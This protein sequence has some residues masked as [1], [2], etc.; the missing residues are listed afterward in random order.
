M[1]ATVRRRNTRHGHAG[2][3]S[4][5]EEFARRLLSDDCARLVEEFYTEG[6]RFVRPDSFPIVGREP[7]RLHWAAVV[8]AGLK[9]ADISVSSVEEAGRNAIG[10]GR[11]NLTFGSGNQQESGAF[12][13]RYRRQDDGSWK[14][15][16][17][18]FHSDS[19]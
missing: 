3:A 6:A 12:F 1:N 9:D 8:Q 18:V 11:Y 10:L 17:H 2:P 14:A 4:A 7:I 5:A 16:E 13:V 15:A 19:A